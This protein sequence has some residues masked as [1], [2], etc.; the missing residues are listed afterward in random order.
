[1]T[2]HE[3]KDPFFIAALPSDPDE[4]QRSLS[5]S[6]RKEM[7]NL[8]NRLA[9]MDAPLEIR[10]GTEAHE[11]YPEILALH[12]RNA[13]ETWGGSL[14]TATNYQ[15][16]YRNLLSDMAFGTYAIHL[17]GKLLAGG[18]LADVPPYR[19]VLL[20]AF[21]PYDFHKFSPHKICMYLV[22]QDAIRQGLSFL[23]L[24]GGISD[25]KRR[26]GAEAIG[27]DEVLVFRD[28]TRQKRYLNDLKRRHRAGSLK[29]AW[30]EG[31]SDE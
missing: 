31:K 11:A 7:R 29:K 6:L 15:N 24:G 4:Y 17:E 21:N 8:A 27:G 16:F 13:T 5:R 19:W 25:Y 22:A 26:L 1:M 14:L 2:R 9:K 3:G 23:D 12:L 18:V 30:Q 20:S 28:A 10:H